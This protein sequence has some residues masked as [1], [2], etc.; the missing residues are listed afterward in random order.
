MNIM[1]EIT[2]IILLMSSGSVRL[3]N[4]CSL[5]R[6]LFAGWAGADNTSG[7]TGCHLRGRFLSSGFC[8]RWR[9]TICVGVHAVQ[10]VEISV[11]AIGCHP[12]IGV[13]RHGRFRVADDVGDIEGIA[14]VV[15]PLECVLT[16]AFQN[17]LAVIHR[18]RTQLGAAIKCVSANDRRKGQLGGG[19]ACAALEPVRKV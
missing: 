12:I 15:F 9:C 10:I 14:A 8:F 11:A 6:V 3:R 2:F 7:C 5:Q 4:V 19:Q 18:D 1:A 16:N 13:E 17:G